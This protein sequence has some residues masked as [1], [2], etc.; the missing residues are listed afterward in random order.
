[1]IL[2]G[3]ILCTHSHV[4]VTHLCFLAPFFFVLFYLHNYML[5]AYI[6]KYIK[7]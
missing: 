5:S 6:K 3:D 4:D 1:M 7:E 2:A